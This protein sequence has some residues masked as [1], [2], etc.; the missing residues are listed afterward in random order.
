MA[1]RLATRRLAVPEWQ[2]VVDDLLDLGE[3]EVKEDARRALLRTAPGSTSDP[4]CRAAGVGMPP[5]F[6]ELPRAKG[7]WAR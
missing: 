2:H 1:D 4:L 5:V 3:I 7:A 6:Q